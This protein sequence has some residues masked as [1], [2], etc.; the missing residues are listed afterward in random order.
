MSK[1]WFVV[2]GAILI[3]LSLGAVYGWS[4]FNQPLV[5]KF[6]WGKEEILVTFSI[7]IATFALFTIF[8]GKAQDKVGPRIVATTGGILLATGLFMASRADS[9]F[10]LYFFYGII[11]GAGIG[12]A[13]VAPLAASVK[14]F[15]EKRGLISGIAVAG[16]GGGG[17]IFK[18]IIIALIE[19]F[20][21]SETFL[22]LGIIYLILVV[23]GAQLLFD[24]PKSLNQKTETVEIRD[25]EFTP[26]EMF[27]T[28]QFYLMW[29]MFLFGTISGLL[30]IG[31]AVDIGVTFANITPKL[32]A[33]AV[34]FIAFFNAAGRIFWGLLSD[35]IGRKN[36]LMLMYLLTSLTMIYLAVGNVTYSLFIISVSVIGFT[37]GGF[38]AV[39]PSKT[40]DYY[41]VENIGV[42]YGIM[43]QAYGIS[44][45]IGPLIANFVPLK[46][47]FLIT[48]TL[49][50]IAIGM[51]FL[52][53]PPR[54][55]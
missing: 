39:F 21:V 23:G 54:K 22:Y 19:R 13:Y 28:S 32:A 43:Y 1:K 6:G 11:G 29:F 27:A 2:L 26:K 5:E 42:N 14:W 17:L 37:F 9:L 46:Q 52:L 44:A 33:N 4:L 20:G 48:A 36:A 16:F 15:P 3:Q 47:A 24:P 34:V 53:R 38:L 25:R 10:Q 40:A 50:L 30:V 8:A 31:Q 12:T 51:T 41:G 55:G 49:S 35:K 45:L 7:T 18:P